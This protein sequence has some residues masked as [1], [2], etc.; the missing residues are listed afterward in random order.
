MTLDLTELALL[1]GAADENFEALTRA[2]V[3]RRFGALGTLRE[4]RQQPGVEFYLRV[5]HRG[6]LGDPGRIWGWS[7]KWFILGPKNELTSGQR[8]QIEESVEKAIK[9]V[10]GLTDFVLCLPQRPAKQDIDWIDGLGMAKGISTKLWAAENFDAQL[11]GLDELRSTF[12]GE[13]VLSPG[14]L[15]QAHE[16]SVAPVKARWVAPLHT[17]NHVEHRIERALLRPASFGWLDDRIAAIAVRVETLRDALPAIGNDVIRAGAQEVVDNLDRFVVDLR[18]IAEAGRNRRPTEARER[19]ADQQPPVTSPRKLRSL[20]FGLRKQRLPAALAVTGLAAE[21][22]DVV[23]WLQDL[24]TDLQAP[25]T[26]IVAAAGTGKTHLAAQL[27]APAERST[28]GVFI[29]GGHLRAGGN[30]DDLARRIPGLKVDR[31]EDLLLALNSAGGRAGARI[32][33]IIDGLNEAERPSEWRPLLDQL[34]PALAS[35]PNVLVVITLREALADRALPDTTTKLDLEWYRAEI[36]DIV[37]AYFNHYLIDAR[38][39]WLPTWMFHN[40]LFLRMYCQAAN[41]LRKNL[42][43]VEA[44]PTSL[45]GVFELYR[46]AVTKRLA[47]DPVRKLVP[48]DQIKRRLAELAREMWTRGIRRLPSDE[49]RVILDAGETDWDESLFRRLEEEGVLLRD[50]VSGSDDTETGILFDRFAGYLIADALLTRMTYAEVEER[51]AEVTLWNSLMGEDHHSFGEDIVI[52]LIGLLPRRFGGHHLWRLAPQEH[53]RWVL[54]QEFASESEYLDEG[55]I[56]EL[57]TLIARPDWKAPTFSRFGRR[58]SFDRLW[59]IR[60][61]P[62]H[63]LNAAFLDRVLRMLPLPERDRRW[64]EWVRH[65]DDDLLL[66]NLK[67]VIEKWSE[68]LDRS[69]GDDLNA[70][71]TAW[72]LTS[73]NRTVRDLATKALQRYGRP[74]PKRLFDLA[75]RMLDVDDPYVVERIVGAAFGAASTHQMPDPGGPFERALARWLT[76]LRDHFLASGSNPTS[77]ELLRSYVRA[78]FEFAGTLHPG[79]VPEGVDPFALPFAT[80][81]PAPVMAENDPNAQECDSTFGMDFENYV[82]G[83]AIRDRG[84]YDFNHAEFRRARGEVMARVWGLGWRA[85]LLG[86]I[87]RAIAEAA[88]RFGRRRVTV[89]RYGKKY[90]WIAY[91]ELTGRLADAGQSRDWWV[92][93]RRNVPPDIDPSFPEEPPTTPVPLPEWAP[94]GPMDDKAWLHAG[95]VKV[96]VDLWLPEEIHD[97]SGGWLLVEGYLK[98]QRDGRKVFGFFRTLLLE[99]DDVNPALELVNGLEYPGNHFFPELP[100]VRSVFAGEAPWSPGF[101]VR[102]DEDDTHSRLALRRDWRDAGIGVGQVAV[103]LSTGEG[104]KPTG[105]KH[106]YDV[107]SFDFAA[108]FKLRQLPGILDLVDL[109]GVRASATFRAEK[110]WSGQLLFIR[111]DLIVDFADHRRIMQVAWGEREVSVDWS[112]VPAWVEEARQAYKHVWREIRMLN[113][114]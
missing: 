44:L 15:A 57:A 50:E 83:S 79:A 104:E 18:A 19:I 12:F 5:E 40:P 90:G 109:N 49:A 65:R 89:E 3:S 84:N 86:D 22:R 63:R 101:E 1:R 35:Y 39:A 6:E 21:I 68:N 67:K 52:S 24:H 27:T 51:L 17:S 43:G 108:R 102:L 53:R 74:D 94:S 45:V 114:P 30:L 82:I 28:A 78:I 26:A 33:L 60:F 56:D 88:G 97:V 99:P 112:S 7:C 47:E 41:P 32:P 9:H 75:I 38:G 46:D 100:T 25:L 16:R 95:T 85:A 66:S 4:R 23:C 76:E 73:T 107:P 31:F 113:K 42:V 91:Y 34:M 8:T 80:V 92:D 111:Q 54:A 71:A 36:N 77:H 61:S 14:I 69:E 37:A 87:D 29:Q 20:V 62:A 81:L 70:L 98:H 105:L 103:E 96:P 11:S 58:H 10:E 48:A 55:T 13:L 72:L 93:G 106:S 2:I 59:E 110:P 64:T